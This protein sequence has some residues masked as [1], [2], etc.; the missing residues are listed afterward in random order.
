MPIAHFSS[1]QGRL[2]H[3]E[4]I[5][6]Q[7]QLASDL[8]AYDHVEMQIMC[9][10]FTDRQ[11]AMALDAALKARPNLT[12]RLIADWSQG[13]PNAPSVVRDLSDENPGQVHVRYKIDLPYYR[14]PT[15]GQVRWGYRAS[16]GML[17]HKTFCILVENSP[18]SL[19]VGSYNWSARGTQAYENTIVFPAGGGD[20]HVIKNFADEFDAMWADPGATAQQADA[21]NIVQ[22]A[23]SM[24]QSGGSLHDL[25]TVETLLD[26]RLKQPE[27]PSEFWLETGK[28]IAAFSGRHL[29][30]PGSHFG[31]SPKNNARKFNLLRPGGL[32]KMTPVSL[33]SLALDAIR[34]V[35]TGDPILVAMYA[36]S[37]RVPEY[38][39][40]LS[41]AR[42]GCKVQVLLDQKIGSDMAAG[43][44]HLAVA[45]GLALKVRTTNRRMH[46]KYLVAPS[47]NTVVTGTANMTHDASTR[48]AEHRILFRDTPALTAAFAADFETIW[49]RVDEYKSHATPLEPA[50]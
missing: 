31:F 15:L 2:V 37:P 36:L 21:D 22:L 35:P 25:A 29:N 47:Q 41:A 27:K 44:H 24:L 6:S 13:A 17:H 11:I 4:V 14:D 43:L 30:D 8:A 18:H 42:R 19:L 33:T 5:L 50:A 48:H 45:E 1:T 12:L 9:F 26:G 23:K 34:S 40:L 3:R 7:I 32:R 20:S 49:G 39:A 28:T 38:N 10:A 16:H 46:Q